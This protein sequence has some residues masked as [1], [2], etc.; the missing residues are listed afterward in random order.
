[1]VV[2]LA[3]ALAACSDDD[4]GG[5]ASSSTATTA[6]SSTTA[7]SSTTVGEELGDGEHVGYIFSLQEM[8]DSS[9]SLGFDLAYLLTGDEAVAAATAAGVELDTDYYVQNDNPRVR[10]LT[11][12][13]D[14]V[15]TVVGE[16]DACCDPVEISLAEFEERI[17]P[18][19]DQGTDVRK[20]PLVRITVEDALV[21]RIDEV[22]LP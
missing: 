21:T 8:D 11:M 4:E 13:P 16:G 14:V 10:S 17:H 19:L 3:L 15:T 9:Y 20:G 7:E 6:S 22:Y 12:A 1:V 2:L 18:T 5:S